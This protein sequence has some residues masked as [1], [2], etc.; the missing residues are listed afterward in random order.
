MTSEKWSNLFNKAINE[1]MKKF[2]SSIEFDYRLAKYDIIGTLAHIEGLHKIGILTIHELEIIKK[3]CKNILNKIDNNQLTFE[4]E[5]IH[6]FLQK[7][8][9]KDIGEL[10]KKIHTARSRNDQVAI[11]LRLYTQHN[12]DIIQKAIKDIINVM[13]VIAKDNLYTI[14]PSYTHLQQ[15]Q[16]TSLAHYFCCYIE[17]LLEDLERLGDLSKRVKKSPLGAASVCGSSIAIDRNYTKDNLQ[18]STLIENSMNAVSNRDFII[19]FCSAISIVIMHLSRFCE[20]IIIYS[21]KEFDFFILDDAFCTGS[22]LMPNKKNPDLLELIRGKSGRIFGNLIS[23]LTIMK[24]LPMS[25]NKDMQEDK[26]SL[27]ETSESI[28]EILDIMKDFITTIKFNKKKMLTSVIDSY[29]MATDLLD[30]L[31][32]CGVSFKDA[33]NKISTLTNYAI[34]KEKYFHQLTLEELKLFD[35]NFR[36]DTFELFD[37]DNILKC[38]KTIGSPNPDFVLLFIDRISKELK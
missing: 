24:A 3:A 29:C 4:G 31:V 36:E 22:S 28:I 21:S 23:I 1:K 18:F 15:A 32:K 14:M 38:H 13:L 34:S 16:V 35:N 30:Y 7:E 8:L 27:F 10:A 5:D 26:K 33:H 9:E 20:D 12:I 11:D 37:F 19:E 6:F 2:N 17:M 25:Y